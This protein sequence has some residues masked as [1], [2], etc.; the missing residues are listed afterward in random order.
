[1]NRLCKH[2]GESFLPCRSV[3]GQEYCSNPI[4]QKARKRLWQ[5]RA[6]ANDPDY[7]DNKKS[8]QKAWLAKNPSYMRDYRARTQKYVKQNRLQQQ[9]RN[10]RRKKS[11]ENK[12][13]LPSSSSSLIVKMD[14][15]KA[16]L[17]GLFMPYSHFRC[18][19]GFIVKMDEFLAYQQP[20]S[21]MSSR[22]VFPG[23][24]C[25]DMTSSPCNSGLIKLWT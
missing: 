1:M 14:E 22:P 3:P 4:C 24:D 17:A 20:F 19:P 5:K 16:C 8:S 9:S 21:A 18:P 6:L 2:C 11:C 25:K 7:R 15:L 12:S 23:V 13:V 10:K